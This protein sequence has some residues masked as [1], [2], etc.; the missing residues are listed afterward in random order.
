MEKLTF[1]DAI[2]IAKECLSLPGYGMN[3][4]EYFCYIG[5][6][7]SVISRLQEAQEAASQK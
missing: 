3:G 5:G 2:K 7:E 1:E 4:N 6:V